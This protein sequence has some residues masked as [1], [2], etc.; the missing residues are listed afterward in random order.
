[1]FSSPV[2]TV[3]KSLRST[4]GDFRQHR[5]R[6]YVRNG[7][8]DTGLVQ[9]TITIHDSC[10]VRFEEPVH[11]AVRDLV[12]AKGLTIEEM[13]HHGKKTLCCGEGGSVGFLAP[14]LAKNWG[15]FR[16]KEAAGRRII[17]YCA[18]C[19][20]YLGSLTPQ[21]MSL[22]CYSSLK[23]LCRAVSESLKRP[24]HISTD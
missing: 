4:G 17:T 22:I 9:G 2:Q 14:E 7:L 23:P 3:T 16:K 5:V 19:A 12:S 11:A 13:P 8:P 6:V 10:A 1:M 20:N 21:A 18:G 15:N 24:S